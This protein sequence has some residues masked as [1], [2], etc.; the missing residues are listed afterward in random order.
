MDY[1]YY[2]DFYNLQN[3]LEEDTYLEFGEAANRYRNITTDDKDPM[4]I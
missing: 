3:E 2:D 1:T 4:E